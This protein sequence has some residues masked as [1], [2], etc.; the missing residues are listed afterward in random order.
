M[1][2]RDAAEELASLEDQLRALTNETNRAFDG[3]ERAV[4]PPERFGLDAAELRRLREHVT[5]GLS[6]S[7]ALE[8]VTV[9]VKDRVRADTRQEVEKLL[10]VAREGAETVPRRLDRLSE[11]LGDAMERL[12]RAAEEIGR[13][14]HLERRRAEAEDRRESIRRELGE[15]AAGLELVDV[16]LRARR[17]ASERAALSPATFVDESDA[18]AEDDGWLAGLAATIRALREALTHGGPAEAVGRDAT[19]RT[20]EV[21]VRLAREEGELRRRLASVARDVELRQ[22]ASRALFQAV[23][24]ASEVLERVGRLERL[25]KTGALAPE[26]LT[27]L[28]AACLE[29]G[30]VAVLL[31]LRGVRVPAAKLESAIGRAA[32]ALGEALTRAPAGAGAARGLAPAWEEL[33]RLEPRAI[34][35]EWEVAAQE[36]LGAVESA[37]GSLSVSEESLTAMAAAD[38][39]EPWRRRLLDRLADR[40]GDVDSLAHRLEPVLATLA[41]LESHPAAAEPARAA[42]QAVETLLDAARDATARHHEALRDVLA[43]SQDGGFG[44]LTRRAAPFAPLR[45]VDADDA[46]ALRT[47][48]LEVLDGVRRLF[49]ELEREAAGPGTDGS[50]EVREVEERARNETIGCQRSL[51]VVLARVR[52]LL[53]LLLPPL[54]PACRDALALAREVRERSALPREAD[55]EPEAYRDRLGAA[56]EA[57]YGE[58]VYLEHLDLPRG[59]DHGVLADLARR[60]DRRLLDLSAGE[61]I[62]LFHLLTVLAREHEAMSDAD[63]PGHVSWI[64]ELLGHARVEMERHAERLERSLLE[65]DT[66][67]QRAERHAAALDAYHRWAQAVAETELGMH[68]L[69]GDRRA[70]FEALEAPLGRLGETIVEAAGEAESSWRTTGTLES[71]IELLTSLARRLEERP[72]I[73]D[74]RGRVERT[75]QAAIAARDAILAAAEEDED[76]VRDPG[77]TPFR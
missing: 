67:E 55:G 19:R 27:S 6:V 61:L 74:V 29:H 3:L 40:A 41:R 20:V 50:A 10:L 44:E 36:S 63:R 65:L 37:D 26:S 68:L 38:D 43:T 76:P 57:L 53:R 47:A 48:R 75:R 14:R 59:A 73:T 30:A 5:H 7:A 31:S 33:A 54:S 71:L 24:K 13:L 21:A 45:N 1:E 60:R 4:L 56:L 51:A 11:R 46:E 52:R 16:A 17:A 64:E 28:K 62:L 25:L 49:S 58:K 15:D 2:L 69:A 8:G 34:E 77:A 9:A 72:T 35:E 23:T 22:E 66:N 18:A 42:R 70:T 39:L 12:R 32:E